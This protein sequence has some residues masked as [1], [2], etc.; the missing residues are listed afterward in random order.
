ME[1]VLLFSRIDI[2]A[3]FFKKNSTLLWRGFL[4]PKLLIEYIN[5]LMYLTHKWLMFKMTSFALNLTFISHFVWVWGPIICC[6]NWI[7]LRYLPIFSFHWCCSKHGMNLLPC[8]I[9]TVYC[10]KIPREALD[11]RGFATIREGGPRV[12]IPQMLVSEMQK[13]PD[14]RTLQ[15]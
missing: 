11:V 7:A 10:T 3:H 1:P 9:P 4:Q 6:N 14:P 5:S 13:S 8:W 2:P 15:L 12:T